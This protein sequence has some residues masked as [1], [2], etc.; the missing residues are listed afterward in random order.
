MKFKDKRF[1]FFEYMLMFIDIVCEFKELFFK[2][3]K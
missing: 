1:S 3:R 2:V